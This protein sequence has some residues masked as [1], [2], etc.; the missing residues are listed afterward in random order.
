MSL[1]LHAGGLVFAWMLWAVLLWGS[2]AILDRENAVNTFKSALGW[3]LV[4][5]GLALAMSLTWFVSLLILAAWVTFLVRLLVHHY[6]LG[7]VRA[8]GV[9]IVTEAVPYLVEHVFAAVAGDS[10]AR[11]LA[12]VW[13][14][15]AAVVACWWWARR[16]ARHGDSA[17]EP[18]RLPR[19]RI[20]RT[21]R[22]D[23][24]AATPAPPPTPQAVPPAPSPAADSPVPREPSM[25]K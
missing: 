3:S 17:A 15:P 4:H 5:V 8:I 6:E 12:I 13:G 10:D 25:L 7:P 11:A 14:F 1:T 23:R 21:T 19:A 2:I 9:I 22:R 18:A 24:R 20:A 16:R